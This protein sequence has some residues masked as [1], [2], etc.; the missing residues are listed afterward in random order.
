M[1]A[2]SGTIFKDNNSVILANMANPEYP[3]KIITV[4]PGSHLVDFAGCDH[5]DRIIMILRKGLEQHLNYYELV[6]PS[7]Y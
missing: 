5:N 1:I 3:S 7:P 2:Y 4:P 6:V